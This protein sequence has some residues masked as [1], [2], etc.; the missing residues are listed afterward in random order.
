MRT[1]M[2]LLREITDRGNLR[3]LGEKRKIQEARQ[4]M[5]IMEED[6]VKGPKHKLLKEDITAAQHGGELEA[7]PAMPPLTQ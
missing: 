7:S 6:I 4:D 2:V 5:D 3:I 1:K